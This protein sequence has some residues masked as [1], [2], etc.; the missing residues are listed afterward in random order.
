MYGGSGTGKSNAIGLSQPDESCLSVLICKYL[1]EEKKTCFISCKEIYFTTKIE[2]D[3]E[4]IKSPKEMIIYLQKI[5]KILQKKRT[6]LNVSSSRSA[7]IIEIY[8]ESDRFI[9]L[10]IPGYETQNNLDLTNGTSLKESYNIRKEHL[11]LGMLFKNVKNNSITVATTKLQKELLHIIKSSNLNIFTFTFNANQPLD[12]KSTLEF[13]SNYSLSLK[14]LSTKTD[15]KNSRKDLRPKEELNND[16]RLESKVKDKTSEKFDQKGRKSQDSLRFDELEKSLE[17]IRV[18]NFNVI[19]VSIPLES[20]SRKRKTFESESTGFSK[21]VK[22][23]KWTCF[24]QGCNQ[25]NPI[26]YNICSNCKKYVLIF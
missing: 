17:S 6:N 8:S 5:I 26:S 3:K 7:V 22:E 23:N 4:E 15:L 14:V 11:F 19:N 24:N 13:T 12:L 18:E 25:E 2:H 16:L 20:P 10:E 21:K 1:L 9:L